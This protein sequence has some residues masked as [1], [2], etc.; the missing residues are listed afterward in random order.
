MSSGKYDFEC[1]RC[2]RVLKCSGKQI[3]DVS[4]INFVEREGIRKLEE[5]RQRMYGNTKDKKKF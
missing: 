4:C 1:A 2:E 5:Y 3:A